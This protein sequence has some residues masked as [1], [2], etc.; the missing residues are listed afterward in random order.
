VARGSHGEAIVCDVTERTQSDAM[1]GQV[2]SALGDPLILVNNAGIAAS[3]KLTETTDEMWDQIM[4]VNATAAFYCTR[5][6]LPAMLSAGWG[7]VVNVASIAA[8]SGAAYIAAHAAPT[9]ASLRLTRAVAPELVPRG[10]T[11]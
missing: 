5:A 1:F 8:R 7:R 2:K 10:S 3:A 9:H 4:R 6:A 11:V